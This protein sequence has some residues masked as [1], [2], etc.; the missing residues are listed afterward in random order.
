LSVLD[1]Q[2][3]LPRAP[4]C[5]KVDFDAVSGWAAQEGNIAKKAE[6]DNQIAQKEAANAETNKQF[7]AM[8]DAVRLRPTNPPNPC[9]LLQLLRLAQR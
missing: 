5:A 2:S 9:I 3:F 1:H 4:C 6:V 8:T 7:Q